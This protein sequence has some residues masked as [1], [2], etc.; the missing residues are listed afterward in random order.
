MFFERVLGTSN[1]HV[2]TAPGLLLPHVFMAKS[3]WFT[4]QY[5]LLAMP[6][7]VP[8][9]FSDAHSWIHCC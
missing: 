1:C 6:G 4:D 8:F 5:P 7:Q 3:P 9:G 2:I